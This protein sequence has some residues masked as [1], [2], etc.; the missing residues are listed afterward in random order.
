MI[1]AQGKVVLEGYAQNDL[2]GEAILGF[3]DTGLAT[4]ALIQAW[5]RKFNAKSFELSPSF[6]GFKLEEWF[7]TER[8]GMP[9]T[10]RRQP[11]RPAIYR[12]L[13]SDGYFSH[14]ELPFIE[15]CAEYEIIPFCFPPHL[16][17][18]IQPLDV[19]V[20]G[21][22]KHQHK[23]SIE[24]N[25]RHGNLDFSLFD[26]LEVFQ[27]FH[28]ESFSY[29]TIL[30]GWRATGLDPK[31][32]NSSMVVSR[33]GSFL[34]RQKE[35]KG[36]MPVVEPPETPPR[37][38]GVATAINGLTALRDKYGTLLSSPSRHVLEQTSV[39]LNRSLVMDRTL[40]AYEKSATERLNRR[41]SRRQVKT[42]TGHIELS[43]IR[44]KIEARD[45]EERRKLM[46]QQEVMVN[47]LRNEHIKEN[48]K[49]MAAEKKAHRAARR[50]VGIKVKFV[51]LKLPPYKL[52]PFHDGA[53]Q[54][55]IP[56][57]EFA[58][59][60]DFVPLGDG[61]SQPGGGLWE[62]PSDDEEE[63]PIFILDTQRDAD[64]SVLGADE[65]ILGFESDGYSIDDEPELPEMWVEQYN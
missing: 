10:T 53:W 18:L 42:P 2:D 51:T 6:R 57:D 9:G 4:P 46:R 32:I 34:G 19:S 30:S 38:Q 8:N 39:H 52:R 17:H 47:K 13:L 21:V 28:R 5:L 20:F 7:D 61:L 16:T 23:I 1:V 62:S 36:E 44:E 11:E 40:E 54:E 31:H 64:L 22:F 24:N 12:M 14:L 49:A 45:A 27:S 65:E 43:Q 3:S 35:K 15:F 25:V 33:L 48:K 63:E 59:Q 55:D 26:F 58:A 50:A 37:V 56:G 60:C 41:K 29:H